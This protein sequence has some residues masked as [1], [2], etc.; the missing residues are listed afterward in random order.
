MA[1]GGKREGAGRNPLPD[2][3]KRKPMTVY[4]TEEMQ[5][6]I[7]FEAALNGLSVGELV[8]LWYGINRRR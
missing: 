6:N 7:G 4:L 8:E 2:D 1:S 5:V 3:D